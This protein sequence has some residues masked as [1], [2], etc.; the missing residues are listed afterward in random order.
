VAA[1]SRR[2]PRP[3]EL[4]ELVGRPARVG[5]RVDR[6]LARARTITDLRVLARRRAPRAVFDYVDGAAEDEL[7][8]W[9][10]RDAFRRLEL[11]PRVL[12]DVSAVDTATTILGRPAALPL[13]FAPTGFTRMMHHEGE[14]AVAAAAGD[15]G[16]PYALSTMGTTSLEDLAADAPQVRRWFQLYLWRDRA[17]SRELV[18]RAAAAGY[19]AL[20]LTVD[21]PVAGARLRDARNGL[22]IPP[23]LTLRTIADAAAH[24]RWWLDLLTREPLRFATLTSWSGTVAELV[25]HMFD[26]A[27]TFDDLAWLRAQG[28]DRVLCDRAARGAPVLG[29]CGGY[30]LL[31]TTV[32]DP[33]GAEAPAGTR[34]RGLGL[35][36]VTTTFDR[37]KIVRRVR[38]TSPALGGEA[39]G[40]ELRHGRVRVTGGAPLLRTD[41]DADEGCL[42]G[43]VLGTSW[44]GLLEHD[45]LR[46]ALLAWV[47]ERARRRYEPAGLCYAAVREAR[48]DR[49]ADLVAEHLDTV[50]LERLLPAGVRP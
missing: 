26:P 36:P 8:L 21:T 1:V 27:V 31:G 3:S 30:Q 18:A 12:R 35:L 41:A 9:R 11:R 47:A 23:A 4:A 17:A 48:H 2:V 28:L 33:G 43:A 45:A 34:V 44:H 37:A 42:A 24:P 10:A 20:V 5:D 32:A 50:S 6:R 49:C 13:A 16:I 46:E 29:L 40:Y 38:G 22:T 15:A 19:E 14:R 39:G 7:S 25:D